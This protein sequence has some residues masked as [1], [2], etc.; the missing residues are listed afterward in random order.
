MQVEVEGPE[1]LNHFFLT[2]AFHSKKAS[3]SCPLCELQ[4]PASFSRRKLSPC[5]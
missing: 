2:Q 3:S 1:F 5:G 4:F